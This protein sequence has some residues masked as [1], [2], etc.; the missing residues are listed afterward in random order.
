MRE[1]FSPLLET[2]PT[3]FAYTSEKNEARSFAAD[4]KNEAMVKQF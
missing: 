3:E 1:F 2:T 4:V